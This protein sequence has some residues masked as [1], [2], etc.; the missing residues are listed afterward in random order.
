MADT[1][2]NCHRSGKNENYHCFYEKKSQTHKSGFPLQ[3]FVVFQVGNRQRH[4]AMQCRRFDTISIREI[5]AESDLFGQKSNC[6]MEREMT[7]TSF[8]TRMA[9]KC[10]SAV[11]SILTTNCIINIIIATVYYILFNSLSHRDGH[12]LV[13]LITLL[14]ALMYKFYFIV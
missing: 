11:T 3:R 2:V 1:L 6:G 8:L 13:L 14:I 12:R 4:D 9:R 5:T 7:I 10:G